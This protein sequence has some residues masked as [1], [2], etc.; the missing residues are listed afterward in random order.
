MAKVTVDGVEYDTEGMTDNAKAQ[1]A[2]L[3]FLQ[4]QMQQINNEIVVFETA[5]RHYL[6]LLKEELPQPQ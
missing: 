1:L 6:Q 2:S 5:K 3:Q 4:A